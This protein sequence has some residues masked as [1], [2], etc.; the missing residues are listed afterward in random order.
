VR[1]IPGLAVNPVN[2]NHIV[3]VDGDP[4]N[5]ECD[6]HVSFDG[7][8]TWKGGHLRVAQG[9]QNPPFPTPPCLQNFDSGGYGHVNTGI[10]FGS[11]QNVYITFSVHR[12][13][14]NRPESNLDGGDGDDAVVARSTNGGQTFSPA[15]V[16]VPGGG[17][18]SANPGLAGIGLRPQLAV[19]RGAG[20]GGAD[21]VYVATWNCYIRV[22]ASQTARGGCSGGGGDRRIWVARSDDGGATWNTPRLASA[23]NVRAGACT[24]TCTPGSA[25]AEAGSS[26]EQAREPSQPVIGPDGAIYVAYRNRD[27]TNGTTCPAN[28]NIS[29][30]AG[31][32][33]ANLAHC[34]VVAR[35][36]DNGQTWAQSST[37]LPI[38][39]GPLSHPRLAIDPNNGAKGTL[40]VS[41]QRA[42]AVAADTDIT[43][44]KSTDGG[45]NWSAP[46]RVNDD[47]AGNVQTNPWVSIGPGGRVNVIWGDRRHPY[48]G[49]GKLADIYFASSTDNGASFGANRRVTDRTINV[50]VGR[51]ND[52]G[53]DFTTGFSWYGPVSQ[54]LPNGHVLNAWADSRLGSFDTGFQDIFLSDLDPAAEIA[55]KNI[56][57]ATSTGLSVA[58]SRLAY[59]GGNEGRGGNG[60]D[61]V[62]KVVVA[63]QDDLPGA[64]AGSVLARANSAPLLLSPAGSLPAVVKAESARIKPEGAFVIGDKSQLSTAVSSA[65]TATT[66]NGENVSRVFAPDSVAA[67]NRT[68]DVARQIAE[69]MRPL[70]GASPEAVIAN[71]KTPDAAAAASLAAALKLPIL[72]V[73]ER[74]AIPPPTSAAITSLGIK[75]LLIVGGNASVNPTVQTALETA[76]GG[77]ANVKRLSG[78]NPTDTSD[79]V[80]AE[81]RLRGLPSNIVYVADAGRPVEGAALGAAVARL[82]GLMLLN[83][84]ADASAAETKVTAFAAA[85]DR[86]VTARGTGGTDPSVPAARPVAPPQTGQYQLPPGKPALAGCPTAASKNLIIL[87]NGN[88]TRNGTTLGDLI[89]AGAGNDNV[90]SL[91]GDD[92]VDLGPGNDRGDGG[93]GDDFIQA[94]LGN[95]TVAGGTGADRLRGFLGNDRL[96]GNGGNDAVVGGIGGDRISGASGNDSL[97]GEN[98]RDRIGGGTGRDGINGGASGDSLQGNGGNDRITGGSGGDRISA[99]SGADRISALDGQRDRINCGSGRDRVTADREDRVSRNCERVRRR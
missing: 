52:F 31:G 80:L 43:V 58:L 23:A 29:A 1:D 15:V 62:T 82:N 14:F 12:G 47:P 83:A 2:Q 27:I 86:I 44:Q 99:G 34:I 66:R 22:R 6:Y 10:V 54:P 20:T 30:P 92:C 53:S 4:I 46:V 21:R 49:G 97:R 68:A 5:G 13:P 55:R 98:G 64:L 84:G 81:A 42:P 96:S 77:A 18:V 71:P 78:A 25:A 9:N 56:A 19:Q 16:A 72:F 90:N 11:G 41:Y 48:P 24:Q 60:G 79:A 65:I 28:P 74:T 3:E 59:P 93:S 75:R 51:Y 95:D 63:N 76:V 67:V 39:T 94:G 32:F 69:L 45:V 17:P 33:P 7:G 38:L 40:Y 26:D 8:K 37:N 70:P 36:T 91:A 57:T 87:T 50:D 61:P 35:S 85:V 88:D 89:F 73:D